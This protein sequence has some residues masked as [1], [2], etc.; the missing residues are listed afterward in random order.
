MGESG[1]ANPRPSSAPLF[2]NSIHLAHFPFLHHQTLESGTGADA[3][4][5]ADLFSARSSQVQVWSASVSSRLESTACSPMASD[6]QG[7]EALHS[8]H[9]IPCLH[10]AISRGSEWHG[11]PG[12]AL[13]PPNSG[14]GRLCGAPQAPTST[15]AA[16]EGYALA[17]DCRGAVTSFRPK[18]ACDFAF[19]GGRCGA[20][21]CRSRMHPGFHARRRGPSSLPRQRVRLEPSPSA[22]LL[23]VTH[24]EVVLGTDG[25]THGHGLNLPSERSPSIV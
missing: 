5:G 17:C 11:L 25:Q 10:P 1:S 2:S 6:A 19:C 8:R 24:P 22:P 9:L 15:S 12:L 7:S 13:T 4:G 23:P 18:T 16:G 3:F 14:R 21:P 20:V